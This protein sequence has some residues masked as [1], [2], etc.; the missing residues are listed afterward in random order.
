MKHIFKYFVWVDILILALALPFIGFTLTS[1]VFKQ[2]LDRTQQLA[3]AE[4]HQNGSVGLA[5]TSSETDSKTY[6]EAPVS[7]SYYAPKPKPVVKSASKTYAPRMLPISGFTQ[8]VIEIL[9]YIAK[10]ESG[11]DPLA[12]NPTSS[13]KGLLQIIDGTW[14]SF[15]CEGYV[16]NADDN[17]N[18][19]IK[20]ATQSGLHHWDAS[21]ACW[22]KQVQ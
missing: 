10:C 13:A 12:R 2:D 8:S 6:L 5:S 4:A 11:N 21:K 15:Q 1:A 19:G 3:I 9:R 16:L 7:P 14:K 18:C 17:F 22:A 20:I